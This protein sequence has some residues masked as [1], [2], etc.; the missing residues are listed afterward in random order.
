[1]LDQRAPKGHGHKLHA[2]A[3]AQ[4]GGVLMQCCCQISRFRLRTAGAQGDGLMA[5]GVT[6]Q[7]GVNVKRPACNQQ[8]VNMGKILPASCGKSGKA[9]GNPPAVETADM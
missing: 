7:G 1:M 4:H 5:G 9:T 3:N 8:S 6:I 2:P